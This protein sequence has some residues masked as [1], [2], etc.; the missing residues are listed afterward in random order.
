MKRFRILAVT[1][2]SLIL[3][4]MLVGCTAKGLTE[5]RFKAMLTVEDIEGVLTSIVVLDTEFFDYKKTAGAVDPA[6]VVNMDSWYGMGF[7]TEDGMKGLTFSLIDFDS[8]ASAQDHFENM[9]AQTPGLETMSLPIG[10]ISAEVEVNAQGVG[11]IIV[12]LKGRKRIQLHTAMPAGEEA[13]VDLEGL[14][15]LARIVESRL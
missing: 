9:R 1:C 12:F 14:E 10:D 8:Q 11:S 3:V 5:G 15:E 2:S 6:Q 7:D 4:A 13:L